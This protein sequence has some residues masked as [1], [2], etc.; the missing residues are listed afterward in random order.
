MRI[1]IIGAGNIGSG[2]ARAWS[3]KGHDI[4]L[5]VRHPNEPK[6]L[7]AVAR[8]DSRARPMTPDA[9]VKEGEIAVLAI[10]F[11][12]VAATLEALGNL[13]GKIVIDCTN[14]VGVTLP[15]GVA[16]G[17]E[18][19]ARLAPGA[20][21][22][23]SFNAQGAE[24]IASPRY[25]NE[26]ASNFYCGDDDGAKRVVRGLIEDVGFDPVDVGPLK[27]ARLIEA[28]AQ[29]WFAASRALGTRRVAFRI[30]REDASE[31]P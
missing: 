20:L 9:A 15:P 2:L 1:A 28:A 26:V 11:G 16:S 3:Q 30:L 13:T 7:A 24:N 21:V 23:K 27:N 10:P 29:L 31:G 19:V 17:A 14:P 22:V 25:A 4:A 8:T 12:A 5:G 18:L 6:T